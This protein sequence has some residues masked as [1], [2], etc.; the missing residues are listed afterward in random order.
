VREVAH[1]P[2]AVPQLDVIFTQPLKDIL[3]V[4]CAHEA[5]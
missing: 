4:S 2:A 3:A 5:S 1:A